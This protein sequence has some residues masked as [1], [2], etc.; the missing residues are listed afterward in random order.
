ML[1]VEREPS[2]RTGGGG[3]A[4]SG[5]YRPHAMGRNACVFVGHR[6]GKKREAEKRK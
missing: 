2:G 4:T 1:K 6:E 5:Q 3:V